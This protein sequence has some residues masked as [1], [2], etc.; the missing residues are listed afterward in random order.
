MKRPIPPFIAR[1]TLWL[2]PLAI[3]A[4]AV[5]VM[6]HGQLGDIA[7]QALA[8]SVEGAR[9]MF[10]M[11][12]L[13]RAWNAQHGG[14]Y[15]P[16]T[17]SVQPNPYLVHPRRDLTTTDGQRLTLVN[18]A[19]MTRLIS[20]RARSDAATV[21]HITSLMPLRP[22]NAPDV[23]EQKALKIFE[24]GGKESIE[25]VTSAASG[26]EMLRYMAPLVVSPPCLVC[27]GKQGYQV[28]DIRGGISV[29]QP[30]APVAAATMPLRRQAI[31]TH[32]ALFLLVALLSGGLLEMLRRRWLNLAE[33]ISDLD[34]ARS[35]LESSNHE[36]V[37]AW[38][39]AE[40]ANVAKS[41]FLANMSH[42]IRT[43]MNAIIGMA[44]LVQKS[45]LPPT[46]RSY[47][48]KIQGA[49]RHLLGVINDILDFSKIEAGKLDLEQREFDLDE[50]FDTVAG[51][52]GER[53]A[54]KNLELVIAVAPNVP[55]QL[56]G[57]GLRLGQVLLNLAGNAVKFT[58]QGEVD[59][60]V[61]V[62]QQDAAGIVLAFAVKDTGI[63]LSEQQISHLFQSFQQADNSVTRK[64]GGTGL[65]L[66]ISKRLVELMGGEI[67]LTSREGVGTTFRFTARFQPG[68]EGK[69]RRL[70]LPDLRNRKAL[71]VDDN[72]TAREVMAMMLGTMTFRVVAVDSGQ[73]ALEAIVQAHAD[74]DPFD[75]VFLDW[76]MPDMDGITTARHIQELDLFPA[77]LTIM[78]TAY[79]K[80]NLGG[81]MAGA[82]IADV[83]NKP[84]TA[85]A[86][87]DTVMNVFARVSH[88]DM[89]S[90]EYAGTHG[91]HD[92]SDSGIAGARV[93]LVEDN[94]LNQ[95]VALAL[96]DDVGLKV[97]V[98]ENGAEAVAK[99][100]EQSY[101]LVLMDM[102][103]PVMDG[104]SATLIL[105]KDPRNA[106]LP[107]VA[108]T[109]NA[110]PSDRARC[111]EV[112]MN[113]HLAKPIDPDRL[114]EALKQ[115]IAP[116]LRAHDTAAKEDPNQDTECPA[117][118]AAIPGLDIK[119]GLRLARGRCEL[120]RK[121][122]RQFARGQRDFPE[123]LQQMLA[124]D[125]RQGAVRLAHTLKGVSA[126]IGAN[127]LR[128]ASEV[129]ERALQQSE[130]TQVIASLRN[131]IAE[132][133]SQLVRG[134]DA[135]QEDAPSPA[136][137]SLQWDAS[138]TRLKTLLD[139][140][141]FTVCQ[142][143]DTQREQLR[144]CF[145]AHF[146]AMDDA[147]HNY[148]F[149][150]ALAV[151]HRVQ[152]EQP[153]ASAAESSD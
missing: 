126:Q 92:K 90:F 125:D 42:E 136:T 76:Q 29:S 35:A 43:P 50:L 80:E 49:S 94:V 19:F 71:V 74:D 89:P 27:H 41:A 32:L 85:S 59:I 153:R 81:Q 69:A 109:A 58:E 146:T 46:Q 9:N 13:T 8:V 115:W 7:K 118:I 66:A 127:G 103:M 106:R 107:I 25:V 83:V 54:S 86:L 60:T 148:E 147:V 30:Y 5:A 47:V 79:G 100:Q 31:R 61:Q 131:N 75:V 98:A 150:E 73:A 140:A 70:P 111:L 20:E 14:V 51:Q 142:V 121:L 116:G 18:P 97:D 117:A 24:S 132:M 16:V 1:R 2:I 34:A 128:T 113:D 108:M 102:Q 110:Q 93:L 38:E 78:V 87:F 151:L 144:D 45:E 6:L 55:T 130:A 143:W 77:P 139:N 82:G 134:I 133:L 37:R 11:V 15:V 12:V 33:T 129:L 62:Q 101:D 56:V 145:A 28:G 112:G 122:L 114:V 72:E 138:F 95:E 44:H 22:G 88:P 4:L 124:Q 152:G 17:E 40:G 10:R 99:V 123:Q 84:V 104:I 48:H 53:V 141:D 137:E 68:G 23:W 52:L 105:R 57:D 91:K 149:E 26:G 39:A 3:W 96:L 120:Y 67:G 64:Y 119:T 21:F 65:G 63:G 135:A 36:L